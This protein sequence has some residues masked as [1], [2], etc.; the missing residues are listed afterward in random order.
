MLHLVCGCFLD[1]QSVTSIWT[2]HEQQ[3]ANVLIHSQPSDSQSVRTGTAASSGTPQQPTAPSS[4]DG[5]H[6]RRKLK[7]IRQRLSS[8]V[9]PLSNT[10]DAEDGNISSAAY[11]CRLDLPVYSKFIAS[12]CQTQAETCHASEAGMVTSAVHTE[13][14]NNAVH[15][16]GQTRSDMPDASEEVNDHDDDD[17]T[18]AA[19]SEYCLE[20]LSDNSPA[21]RTAAD[22]V[23][24]DVESETDVH[25]DSNYS[26]A[27]SDTAALSIKLDENY[28]PVTEPVT[29]SMTVP[30]PP[31]VTKASTAKAV[32]RPIESRR[33]N[34]P[35]LRASA[36]LPTSAVTSKSNSATQTSIVRPPVGYYQQPLP[37]PLFGY[38]GYL[39]PLPPVCETPIWPPFAYP[40][41]PLPWYYGGPHFDPMQYLPAAPPYCVVPPSAAA[42]SNSNQSSLPQH[43][44]TVRA[45]PDSQPAV[46]VEPTKPTVVPPSS[47][48]EPAVSTAD[49][50]FRPIATRSCF[51]P[52][53]GS[54]F[55][56][57]TSDENNG[58]RQI[59]RSEPVADEKLSRS[60]LEMVELI[61][62]QLDSGTEHSSDA[63]EMQD[64]DDAEDEAEREAWEA[65]E[66]ERQRMRRRHTRQ[67]MRALRTDID[68]TQFS[69]T[70]F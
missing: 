66:R 26:I 56:P 63:S 42:T 31:P 54:L 41:P 9:A 12:S 48:R 29:R 44:E 17:S 60:L 45:V 1:L 19:E 11:Q 20:G 2:Q 53:A 18:V 43:S 51:Q 50:L 70:S 36:S 68:H 34:I 58:R 59:S 62:P 46:T 37:Y 39:P 25:S 38:G 40:P 24:D 65:E 32:V 67:W 33:P 35:V 52:T 22:A 28:D 4:T 27:S 8:R 10:T 47:F 61:T 55:K 23:S 16:R 21:S 69:D 3:T 57:V 6:S 5:R 64:N 7:N 15:I 13:S 49:K 30:A 14:D